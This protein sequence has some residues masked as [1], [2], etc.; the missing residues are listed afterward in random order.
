MPDQRTIH[1]TAVDAL[2]DALVREQILN[3]I[4]E[5]AISELLESRCGHGTVLTSL[6]ALHAPPPGTSSG[7]CAECGTFFPCRTVLLLNES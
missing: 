2:L 1:R 5:R 3:G 7:T 6:R 4:L